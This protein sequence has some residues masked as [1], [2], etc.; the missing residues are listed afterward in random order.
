M[1]S[2]CWRAIC[3]SSVRILLER[4]ASVAKR[5]SGYWV[6]EGL[7]SGAGVWRRVGSGACVEVEA[8]VL[9]MGDGG[10]NG[11]KAVEFRK[12]LLGEDGVVRWNE[13]GVFAWFG[14]G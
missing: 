3:L 13:D 11:D 5:W 2:S 12:G 8:C 9:K 10:G 4:L 14:F 7:L 6:G 1:I